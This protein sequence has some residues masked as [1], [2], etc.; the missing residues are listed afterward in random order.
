MLSKTRNEKRT[1]EAK[2]K[3]VKLFDQRYADF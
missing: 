2:Q 3:L 1:S